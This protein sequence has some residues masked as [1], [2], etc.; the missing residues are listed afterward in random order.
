MSSP[1][2][3]HSLLTLEPCPTDL[4]PTRLSSNSSALQFSSLSADGLDFTYTG[5]G[6]SSSDVACLRADKP[7]PSQS[8]LYYFELTILNKGLICA[9]A[10][11]IIPEVYNFNRHPGWNAD[12]YAYH[13]DDGRLFAQSGSGSDFYE[14]ATQGDIIGMGFIPSEGKLIFVKNGRIVGSKS[15]RPRDDIK[16]YPSVGLHSPDERVKVNFAGPFQFDVDGFIEQCKITVFDKLFAT[17]SAIHKN[18]MV[19][20]PLLVLDYLY[21]RSL[22]DSFQSMC[23]ALGYSEKQ[24]SNQVELIN[25]RTMVTSAIRAGNSELAFATLSED[26]E[27]MRVHGKSAALLRLKMQVFLEEVR[28]KNVDKALFLA[29]TLLQ[30]DWDQWLISEEVTSLPRISE[31]TGLLVYDDPQ[32]SCLSDLISQE[33]RDETAGLLYKF[34]VSYHSGSSDNFYNSSL[35][36]VCLRHFLTLAKDSL[37]GV[38]VVYE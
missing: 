10:I 11:G 8:F 22:P 30:N 31:L 29:R 13:A 25:C 18:S 37:N 3:I 21:Q 9:V 24:I 4:L 34:L 32:E 2:L 12:S 33:V 7:I 28:R 14:K 38:K 23:Q 19:A 16:F 17:S 36:S 5:V 15:I 35:L 20:A 6:D 26:E 1:T 27:L